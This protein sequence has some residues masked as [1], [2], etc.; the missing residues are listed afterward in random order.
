MLQFCQYFG[1]ARV[2]ASGNIVWVSADHLSVPP[3]ILKLEPAIRRIWGFRRLLPPPTLYAP[4]SPQPPPLPD[5]AVVRFRRSGLLRRAEG[6][7][8]RGRERVP[9]AEPGGPRG[10]RRRARRAP[11]Q[12]RRGLPLR[13]PRPHGAPRLP[14]HLLLLPRTHPWLPPPT[15]LARR[16]RL[17]CSQIPKCSLPLWSHLL[18][19]RFSDLRAKGCNLLGKVHC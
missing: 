5:D 8:V 17:F 9:V 6:G 1:N 13:R 3:E 4:A 12:R 14:R 16:D 15:T 2:L 11:P 18:Q 19:E 7:D 10:V